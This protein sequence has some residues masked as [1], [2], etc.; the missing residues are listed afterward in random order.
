MEQRY[1]A[2]GEAPPRAA[3]GRWWPPR[4]VLVG[5]A[6]LGL[7]CQAGE[8]ADGEPGPPPGVVVLEPGPPPILAELLPGERGDPPEMLEVVE[9]VVGDGPVVGVGDRVTAHVAIATW[10][11]ARPIEDSWERGVPLSIPVGAGAVIAGLDE[12]LLGMR[13]GGRRALVIPAALAYADRGVGDRI[14]PD[15]DLLVVVEV[16]GVGVG[17]PRPDGS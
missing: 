10:Q 3:A 15:E 8:V 14:A 12:G 7:A 1:P 9:L 17:P 11:E 16:V 5:L 4:A 2:P 6:L 13:V